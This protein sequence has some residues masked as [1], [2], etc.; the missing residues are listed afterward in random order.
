MCNYRLCFSRSIAAIMND[1]YAK[2]NGVWWRI[3]R[4]IKRI[5][6]LELAKKYV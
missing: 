5:V 6:K 3:P 1:Y 2:Y 4:E